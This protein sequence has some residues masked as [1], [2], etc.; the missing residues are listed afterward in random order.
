MIDGP[1]GLIDWRAHDVSGAEI[2][3][4][5]LEI[6]GPRRHRCRRRLLP[7]AG[8]PAI[9]LDRN[10]RPDRRGMSPDRR[11]GEAARGVGSRSRSRRDCCVR[12]ALRS[13]GSPG[14]PSDPGPHVVGGQLRAPSA[15]VQ[16]A[17]PPDA[18]ARGRA[19]PG[20]D[21]RADP[22]AV[23]RLAGGRAARRTRSLPVL[24]RRGVPARTFPPRAARSDVHLRPREG[25]DVPAAARAIPRERWTVA[26]GYGG[27]RLHERSSPVHLCR[28][29][30]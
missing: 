16:L 3:S 12:G 25:G 20:A 21:A 4:G 24:Q 26:P 23:D 2:A 11:R 15:S 28:S 7:F 17:P 13:G 14:I 9:G 6:G 1:G 30:R 27:R 19:Q 29:P 22:R 8:G 10:R 18:A 5:V